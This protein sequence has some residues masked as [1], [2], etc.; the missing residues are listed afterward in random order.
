MY[1]ENMLIEIPEEK[2]TI[3]IAENNNW[4]RA[5][6]LKSSNPNFKEG[7]QIIINNTSMNKYKDNKYF[8]QERHVIAK[9]DL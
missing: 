9:G 4:R 7:D 8:I 1:N 5:I 3:K 6:V 2:A